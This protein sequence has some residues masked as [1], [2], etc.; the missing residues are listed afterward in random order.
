MNKIHKRTIDPISVKK[1][2]I[3][4]LR[5]IGDNI[6]TTPVITALKENYPR[7]SLTYLVEEP[8]RE[9]V[10]GNPYLDH[11]LVLPRKQRTMDLLKHIQSIRKTKYD[12]LI[13]LFGGPKAA[14]ITLFAKATLKIGYA[15]K[16]KSFIY[17]IRIPRSPEK[18]YIH[19]V[20]NHINL[21]RALGIK[22]NPIPPPM[23]PDASIKEKEKLSRFIQQ[24]NLKAYKIIVFHIGAGN[25]FRDWGV[26]N[27]VELTN[28]FA[29]RPEIKIV[30]VGAA[31]EKERAEEII[32]KSSLELLT[33]TGKLGLKEL[34]ELISRADLFVG[35]DS[36]PMHLA[37]STDTPI[38]AYFGPTL[39]ARFRPWQAKAVL[40]EKDYE[41]RLTCR[42][43]NCV[44]E[45]FRCIRDISPQDV[46]K[47]CLKFL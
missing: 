15:V 9:I 40:L 42:Q 14:W 36:G 7:A 13:D 11:I 2:L 4:R 33:L 24:N 5:R 16:Y 35:P 46:Y 28:L 29:Q 17:N 38:V 3:I 19:S 8:S 32:K 26:N 47:A 45:D 12:V 25:I 30:L 22:V 1:I 43:R 10:E 18:G 6:M 21:I 27:I 20:E 31:K 34:R 23:V 39:P 37:A 44:Y 41:C